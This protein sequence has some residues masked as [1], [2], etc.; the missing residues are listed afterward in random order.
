MSLHNKSHYQ[1]AEMFSRFVRDLAH[2]WYLVRLTG[3]RTLK[4]AIYTC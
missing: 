2:L 3:A 1:V 4:R